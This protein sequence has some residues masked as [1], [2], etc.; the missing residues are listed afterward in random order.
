M[1]RHKTPA[2]P[3][4]VSETSSWCLRVLL[5][6]HG[7]VRHK[8]WAVVAQSLE[9]SRS[10]SDRK[11][12]DRQ[13]LTPPEIELIVQRFDEKFLQVTPRR[14]L[15]PA[16]VLTITNRKGGVGK[17]TQ[18]VLLAQYLAWRGSRV[19]ALDFDAQGDFSRP[20]RASGKCVVS[21]ITADKALTDTGAAVEA[22]PFVLMGQDE[23][24]LTDLERQPERY[25]EF[26][27]NLRRF[28]KRH[29]E[30]FDYVVIDTNPAQDIR[31]LAALVAS[32]FVL[33]PITLT[34]EALAGLQGLFNDP[35]TGIAAVKANFNRRLRFLGMLPVMVNEQNIID[36]ECLEMLMGAPAY[37]EQM[38][39]TV[40]EPTSGAQYLR[41]KYRTVWRSM[42]N[43]G[44]VL[45]EMKGKPS[46]AVWKEVEPVVQRIAQL[47]GAA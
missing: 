14:L 46:E 38:L 27:N 32:D 26:A 15:M 7:V 5:D 16:R 2:V 30:Q 25:T 34:K 21:A 35:R 31:V 10:Q 11:L 33:A 4:G 28:L 12:S 13:S 9:L 39:A 24:A 40:D 19:L 42:H 41:I 44:A 1:A 22:A 36:R 8:Q 37:R 3:E 43:S 20:L 6:R 45:W 17:S 29:A 18:A 47:I 23:L